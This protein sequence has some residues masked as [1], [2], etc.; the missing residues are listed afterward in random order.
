MH[1]EHHPAEKML[2]DFAG[3][4]LNY[5]DKVNGELISCPVFVAVLPY[6]GYSYVMALSDMKQ[7]SVVVALNKAIDYFGG[8]PQGIKFDN[9]RQVV[10]K[11]SR[12]EPVFTDTM[13]Q[14]ALHN[15]ITLLAARPGKP[16]DK[17]HVENE[18]KQAYQR[19]YAPLRKEVFYSLA[20]MNNAITKQL[21]LHHEMNFQR[22]DYSRRDCFLK[23][24]S[25][26]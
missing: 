8:M 10:S 16:K 20:Q 17:P 13:Q 3:D 11:S 4:N 5:V 7:P 25:R 24:E 15:N 21:V 23:E 18:V 9:M 19:I 14:W 26:Y 12:Y 2:V 1:F 22:K 6:S